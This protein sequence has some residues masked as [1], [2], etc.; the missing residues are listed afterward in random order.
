MFFM[1]YDSFIFIKLLN[2]WLFIQNVQFGM[3]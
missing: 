3:F 1:V 2:L